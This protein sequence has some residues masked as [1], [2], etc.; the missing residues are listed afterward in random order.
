MDTFN[1]VKSAPASDEEIESISGATISSKAMA[2][3]VNAALTY[4]RSELGG[5]Q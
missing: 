2:N 5:A 4:F 1:V 3:G